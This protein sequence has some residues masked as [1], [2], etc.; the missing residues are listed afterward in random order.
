[1]AKRSILVSDFSGEE[2]DETNGATLRVTYGDSETVHVAD[3]TA[4]EA[5]TILTVKGKFIARE[6]QKRG[7]KPGDASEGNSEDEAK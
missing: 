3:L 6:Q 7:R 1:M 5:K 2:V 4:D